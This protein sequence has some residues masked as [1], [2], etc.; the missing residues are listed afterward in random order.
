MGREHNLIPN[1]RPTS[2]SAWDT[3]NRDSHIELRM[4]GD[5][6]AIFTKNITG[7]SDAYVR[8]VVRS[9]DAGDYVYCANIV[10]AQAP[11]PKTLR[12]ITLSPYEEIAGCA[13]RAGLNLV[14]FTLDTAG[15][16]ELR[17]NTCLTAGAALNF[18]H[19]G[20]YTQED[21]DMMQSMDDPVR[22]FSGD[23]I[24]RGGGFLLGLFVHMWMAAVWWWSHDD[25]CDYPEPEHTAEH[26][27]DACLQLARSDR[28]PRRWWLEGHAAGRHHV[29]GTVQY[30]REARQPQR[31]RHHRHDLLAQRILRNLQ[32]CG[33]RHARPYGHRRAVG[34][35]RGPYPCHLMGA[36]VGDG[37][38]GRI[39]HHPLVR[40]LQPTGLGPCPDA[41]PGWATAEPALDTTCCRDIGQPYAADTHTVTIP[42]MGVVA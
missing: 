42:Q 36:A 23:E 3:A 16:V 8:T 10:V 12:V 25:D 6:T 26:D 22:W 20:L 28:T 39:G 34:D 24:E 19:V 41:V 32:L 1:P 18:N 37:A 27:G 11:S 33:L 5:G 2:V 29:T 30:Q 38:S 21:F 9:L 7:V 14:R 15:G 40:G 35:D 31:G 17:M 4:T 13:Y